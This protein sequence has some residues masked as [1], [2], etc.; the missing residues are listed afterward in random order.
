MPASDEIG[1]AKLIE[2]FEKKQK[3]VLKAKLREVFKRI[4]NKGTADLIREIS[5]FYLSDNYDETYYENTRSAKQKR[6]ISG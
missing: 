2:K 6:A 5:T 4:S 1:S 3:E